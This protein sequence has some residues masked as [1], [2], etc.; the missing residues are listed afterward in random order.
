LDVSASSADGLREVVHSYRAPTNKTLTLGPMVNAPSIFIEVSVFH[1]G[2]RPHARV[3]SQPEYS[4][5]MAVE[6][7]QALNQQSVKV[8]IV[9]TTAAYLGGRP[10]TWTLTVPDLSSAG[11]Q[12]SWG[13][14]AGDGDS[15]WSVTGF[16]GNATLLLGG[17]AADGATL[18]SATRLSPGSLLSVQASIAPAARMVF[19]RAAAR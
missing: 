9:M 11:Y 14:Q 17:P 4:T 16:E 2:I 7:L 5:A 12:T 18:V 3:A 8:V 1:L 10:G 19:W 13:L 6:Y 15:D